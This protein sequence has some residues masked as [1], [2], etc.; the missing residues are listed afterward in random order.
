MKIQCKTCNHSSLARSSLT[1][2]LLIGSFLNI[3]L[4]VEINEGDNFTND[5]ISKNIEVLKS[6]LS[7]TLL[8][9]K[10]PL[11]IKNNNTPSAQ[12]SDGLAKYPFLLFTS[13][14]IYEG[15]PQ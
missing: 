14:L 4:S 6:D 12:T 7:V 3:F 8:K 10:C 5:C 13:G 11:T 15:V 9:G 2:G 1:V